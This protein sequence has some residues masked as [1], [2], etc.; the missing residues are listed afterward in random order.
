MMC[1]KSLRQCC[2]SVVT[3]IIGENKISGVEVENKVSGEKHTFDIEG[4]FVCI[5]RGPDT[6]IIE[7]KLKLDSAGYIVVD[8]NMKTNYDGVYAIGDIRNTPLR[9]VITACSD[10]AIAST[11]AFEYIR[12][13]KSNNK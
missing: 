6:E 2:D 1:D 3:K 9:Q 4:L 8:E 7:E 11:K 12:R 13:L 5:G 10:G